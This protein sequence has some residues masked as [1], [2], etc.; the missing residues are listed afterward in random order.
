MFGHLLIIGENGTDSAEVSTGTSLIT[1]TSDKSWCLGET[2]FVSATDS[3]LVATLQEVLPAEV[4]P[5]DL[6][7]QDGTSD[8]FKIDVYALGMLMDHLIDQQLS[9][10]GPFQWGQLKGLTKRM[11]S[12]HAAE[13]PALVEALEHP[14]FV[15]NPLIIVGNF[16]KDIKILDADEK[17]RQFEALPSKLR[18]LP[19]STTIA[20]IL[21]LLLT[22]D[23][24][25]EPGCETL[26][27][28]L[29]VPL[30]AGADGILP[31]QPYALHVLPFLVDMLSGGR[32]LREPKIQG[33]TARYSDGLLEYNRSL[34]EGSLIPELV[35]GLGE[36]DPAIHVASLCALASMIPRLCQLQ[37]ATSS[38]P[39]TSP[40]SAVSLFDGTLITDSRPGSVSTS[41]TSLNSI[42]E[43]G[44]AQNSS[45]NPP[46]QRTKSQSI[47]SPSFHP[48]PSSIPGGVEALRR[49]TS[50][51]SL[52]DLSNAT[53]QAP[54]TIRRMGS[55]SLLRTDAAT[56][57]RKKQ[58]AA[59]FV[60]TGG[61]VGGGEKLSLTVLV[62]NLIIPHALNICVTEGL[63]DMDRT[64]V[65]DALIALW[66][67]MCVVE[68]G[69][70][71]IAEVRQVTRS[72]LKS[73]HLLMKVVP[74]AARAQFFSR[75]VG[76]IEGLVDTGTLS[77]LTRIVELGTPFLRDEHREV[78]QVV[79][80]GLTRAIN[81]IT[82]SMDR[83]PAVSRK[84]DEGS[85]ASKLKKVYGNVNRVKGVFPIA[86][87]RTTT[88]IQRSP[89]PSP[90]HPFPS[91]RDGDTWEDWDEGFGGN[92]DP[93]VQG[94]RTSAVP[95]SFDMEEGS[96][97]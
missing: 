20:Y 64:D 95:V 66:K 35:V 34:L 44:S 71:A 38:T 83:A 4:I 67:R 30:R 25:S 11:R 86:G 63:L 84:R 27:A 47:L 12:H 42:D 85:I 56:S 29:F 43:A 61:G 15:D 10:G 87:P 82:L 57:L 73:F 7:T 8:P 45:T 60:D 65:L 41:T 46:L 74:P 69:N 36:Q 51:Q 31:P 88:P 33:M 52:A 17:V 13:R 58:S 40:N 91:L 48:D 55:T 24:F 32:S 79:S 68:A 77:I 39:P 26:F 16:L 97:R 6:F 94:R 90:L 37:F 3:N 96:R 93:G 75:L 50:M 78:R 53:T 18:T 70:K 54:Q 9:D 80:K 22:K 19:P 28:H 89:F 2:Q 23:L 72:L 81:I 76:D 49:K 92:I 59:S 14:F 1:V 21:P 5:P 62:E